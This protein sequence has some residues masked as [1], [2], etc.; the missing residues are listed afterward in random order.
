MS[1]IPQSSSAKRTPIKTP[2]GKIR[3]PRRAVHH[4]ETLLAELSRRPVE[5]ATF[6]DAHQSD[7]PQAA[8]TDDV[9]M[10]D[11]EHEDSRLMAELFGEGVRC[12]SDNDTPNMA[13]ERDAAADPHTERPETNV[14]TTERALNDRLAARQGYL[15]S[16]PYMHQLRG[17]VEEELLLAAHDD[18]N[19]TLVDSGNEGD[20]T[21]SEPQRGFEISMLA[22]IICD[23]NDPA[24]GRWE[25]FYDRNGL[26]GAMNDLMLRRV[27]EVAKSWCSQDTPRK[28]F[29]D[30]LIAELE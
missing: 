4:P 1:K 30:L 8:R 3:A 27:R 14:K 7:K 2:Q 10:T 16:G 5:A 18:E 23:G 19:R 9:H 11:P 25:G 28:N 6:T 22:A 26:A 17:R 29:V 13:D 15:D 20:D 24:I 12:H 21:E